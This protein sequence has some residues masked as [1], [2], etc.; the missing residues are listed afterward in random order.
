MKS[1][2]CGAVLAM[3]LSEVDQGAVLT[4]FSQYPGVAGRRATSA[5]VFVLEWVCALAPKH[6][7]MKLLESGRIVLIRT[8]AVQSGARSSASRISMLDVLA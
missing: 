8:M 3:E 1:G 4:E 5:Q 6:P 2:R 7:L